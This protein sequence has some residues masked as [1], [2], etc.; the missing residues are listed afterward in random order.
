DGSLQLRPPVGTKLKDDDEILIVAE[1]DSTIEYSSKPLFKTGD[2]EK[3]DIHLDKARKNI[4]IIGWHNVGDIFIAES[5]DYLLEGSR[6]DILYKNPPESLVT[7]ID[8]LKKKY[9]G[10]KLNMI[11]KDPFHIDELLKM[12][13]FGYDN[14]LILSQE[15]NEMDAN[16]I[17]SDT[18]MILLLLRRI[19]VE[20]KHPDK[21]AKIITQ[22]LNSEN[23]EL[24]IQAD[25]DDFII[26]NKLITMILAQL[27][28]EPKIK[29]LY[30]D[31]FQE[32]GSEIY[33]K[34]ARLY[35]S[36]LPIKIGFADI[37]KTVNLREEICLGVRF[38]HL[39]TTPDKNFGVVLNPNKDTVYEIKETDFLV[40]LAEDEL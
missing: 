29:L 9:P 4:L 16:K 37:M 26:S 13:P 19:A 38:G 10:L 7:T 21:H 17:D 40:V 20:H 15:V 28:E 33:V 22:V 11:D 23:Q 2:V 14:I 8:N 34:P 3:L 1:D 35:F 36:Q 25:V 12:D 30:D 32:D 31:I 39:S 24:I 6:F 18:L 27:S 5:N